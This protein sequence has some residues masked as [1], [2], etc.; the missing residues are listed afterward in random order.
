MHDAI[1]FLDGGEQPGMTRHTPHREG[2]FVIHL[3]DQQA[4]A[5]GAD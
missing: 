5:Q 2:V 4:L 3:A 1:D